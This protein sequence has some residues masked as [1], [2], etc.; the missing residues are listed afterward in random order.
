VCH[1]HI[2]NK[3]KVNRRGKENEQSR[4]K[5]NIGLKRGATWIPT[6][7]SWTHVIRKDKQFPHIALSIVKCPVDCRGKNISMLRG[8]QV[9]C[10][11][12][13]YDQVQFEES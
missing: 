11:I 5:D 8:K 13:T 3:L 12:Q 1:L 4:K 10:Q 7:H 2:V 9:N 6:Q